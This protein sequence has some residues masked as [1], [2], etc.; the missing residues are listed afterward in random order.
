MRSAS[1]AVVIP[2]AAI[3][4]SRI[5]DPATIANHPRLL[6]IP[7]TSRFLLFYRIDRIVLEHRI[8]STTTMQILFSDLGRPLIDP[9]THSSEAATPVLERI[10][11]KRIPF[12]LVTDK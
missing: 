8:C 11:N 1:C 3:S 7:P 12:V 5:A 4:T 9:L 10:R 6:M 2:K